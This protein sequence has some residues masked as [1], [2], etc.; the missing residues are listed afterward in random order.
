[1][2]ESSAEASAW[3]TASLPDATSAGSNHTRC[4]TATARSGDTASSRR[5]PRDQDG[6]ES[7]TR[8]GQLELPAAVGRALSFV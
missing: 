8:Q 6:V 5:R 4:S 7:E 3:A 2:L 1:M